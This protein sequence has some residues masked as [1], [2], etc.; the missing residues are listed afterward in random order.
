MKCIILCAGYATRL[1]PLTLT[2]PKPLLEING[3]PIVEH[4]MDRLPLQ[5]IDH[6][7]LISNNKF[8]HHFL[9]WKVR[10][11]SDIPITIINDRTKNNDDRLGSIGDMN[12]VF[13]RTHFNDDFLLVSG[14][15][16][17]NFDLEPMLEKYH[18]GKNI[19]ALHDV[20]NI[21]EAQ[22][23]GVPVV[24]ANGVVTNLEEKPE[25]PK[26]TLVSI[27]IYL[28]RKEVIGLLKKYLN[29]GN[30]PDK[31]GDFVDWL[32]Q[33]VDLHTFDFDRKGDIW[34]DIGTPS[35]LHLAAD[36]FKTNREKELI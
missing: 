35:Q 16:L 19:I 21:Y 8:Y 30:L 3:K 32:C 15:N 6:I 20:K 17:F 13:D 14:D 4:I 22:K 36:L 25:N 33:K 26:S 29:E 34:F 11:N 1:Y 28:F 12:F 9:T 5:E 24:N 18:S 31:V 10:Y 2:Q 27:G 7:Y 23:M